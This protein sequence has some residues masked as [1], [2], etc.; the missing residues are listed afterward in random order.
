MAHETDQSPETS[1]RQYTETQYLN[2]EGQW[3]PYVVIRSDEIGRVKCRHRTVVVTT[4]RH[5]SE[6]RQGRRASSRGA[7]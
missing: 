6:W 7:S 3:L 5:A 1:V 2:D 4:T